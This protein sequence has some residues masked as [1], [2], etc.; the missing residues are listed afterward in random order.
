MKVSEA[1]IDQIIDE[2][3][4][5]VMDRAGVYSCI[6]EAIKAAKTAQKKLSLLSIEAR[7][8]IIDAMRDI[9]ISNAQKLALMAI[10]ETG[11]GRYEDKI[12]KNI[13]AA[14]KTPGTEDR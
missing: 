6:D 3:L 10:E 7:T 14:K 4:I 13:L 8:K 11:M 12:N 5:Q 1:L 2:V 9:I